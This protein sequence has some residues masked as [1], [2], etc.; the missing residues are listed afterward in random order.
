MQVYFEES[1]EKDLKRVKDRKI[2]KR[3]KETIETIKNAESLRSLTNIQKLKGYET[4]YRIRLGDFRLGIEIEGEKVIF[5]R[6]LHRKD[7]YR[8]FP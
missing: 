7:I 5:V 3:V 1:F 8:Y 2:L 4:Y 6:F